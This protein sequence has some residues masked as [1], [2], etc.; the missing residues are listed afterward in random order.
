MPRHCY[1]VPLALLLTMAITVAD[2]VLAKQ[3]QQLRVL[4]EVIVEA[5]RVE[6]S[7]Q[8]APVSLVSFDSDAMDTLG[9]VLDNIVLGDIIYPGNYFTFFVT[10]STE[11]GDI[12]FIGTRFG[13]AVVENIVVT[14]TLF[15]AGCIWIIS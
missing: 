2:P 9:I 10:S 13:I 3:S 7:A 1:T 11:V 6:E 8:T 14:V 4:E 12:H 15:T 5:R